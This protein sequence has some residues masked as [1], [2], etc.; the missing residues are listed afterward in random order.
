[1]QLKQGKNPASVWDCSKE[2]PPDPDQP[3]SEIKPSG[4]ETTTK[5]DS[6]ASL[7]WRIRELTGELAR[8]EPSRFSVPLD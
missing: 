8:L 3:S 7:H 4:S 2:Q 1:M 5:G 6:V